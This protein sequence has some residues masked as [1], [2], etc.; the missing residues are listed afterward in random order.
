MFFVF[1]DVLRRLFGFQKELARA[2]DAEAVV[3]SFG[4]GLCP[5]RVFVDHF[6]VGFG[7]PLL[8]VDVPAEMLEEGV[9]ELAAELGAAVLTRNVRDFALSSVRIET[10]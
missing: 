3:R 2:A 4:G 6:L 7:E 8:V 9:E 1:L 10:Y 5:E